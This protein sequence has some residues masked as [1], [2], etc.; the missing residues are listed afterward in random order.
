LAVRASS[1]VDQRWLSKV[2]FSTGLDLPPLVVHG[3]PD[4]LADRWWLLLLRRAQAQV[5]E[6][7]GHDAAALAVID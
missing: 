7:I 5:G 3:R 2:L 6:S 4:H 1:R